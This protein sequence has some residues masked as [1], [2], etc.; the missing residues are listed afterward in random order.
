MRHE[1]GNPLACDPSAS[2]DET[3]ARREQWNH[4]FN[5]YRY[6]PERAAACDK[7]L[8]RSTSSTTTS[9]TRSDMLDGEVM[10]RMMDDV[11]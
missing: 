10:T 8:T 4:T 7:A 2:D 3:G 9:L 11:A 6:A 1:V 5:G